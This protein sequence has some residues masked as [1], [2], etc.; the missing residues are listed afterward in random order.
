MDLI[1]RF[2]HALQAGRD[3]VTSA[4]EAPTPTDSAVAA[5][6]IGPGTG[7]MVAARAWLRTARQGRAI[8]ITDQTGVDLY[9][10]PDLVTEF[11]PTGTKA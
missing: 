2:R 11:L 7:E 5:L 8:L 3:A 1:D 9:R 4:G 6:V 10:D